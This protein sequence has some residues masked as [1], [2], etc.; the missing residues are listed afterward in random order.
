[1]KCISDELTI[2]QASVVEDDMVIYV[3]NGLAP[4]FHE[5]SRDIQARDNSITS[6]KMICLESC[7][8][9]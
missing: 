4:K 9:A 6:D 5:I 2:V 7:R 8:W 1:M 3:F